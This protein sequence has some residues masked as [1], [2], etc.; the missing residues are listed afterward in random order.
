MSFPCE[1]RWTQ[2]RILY[3]ICNR[4]IGPLILR[5]LKLA[6]VSPLCGARIQTSGGAPAMAGALPSLPCFPSRGSAGHSLRPLPRLVSPRPFL[7]LRNLLPCLGSHFP[8]GSVPSRRF[9]TAAAS[10]PVS[11]DGT[12]PVLVVEDD[13]YSKRRVISLTPALYSYLMANVR[14]Q[15]VRYPDGRS[16]FLRLYAIP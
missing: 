3:R 13:K 8:F 4:V 5:R 1:G 2:I 15:P 7:S 9:F 11:A 10:G 14:E 6:R 12:S 16:F